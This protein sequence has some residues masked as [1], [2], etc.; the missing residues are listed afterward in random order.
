[1]LLRLMEAMKNLRITLFGL[2]LLLSALA[3]GP[4][5]VLFAT[6][7]VTA[8]VAPPP[9]PLPSATHA[10]L[11]TLIPSQTPIPRTPLPTP[12]GGYPW[13]PLDL[14]IFPGPL[15]YEGDVLTIEVAVAELDAL[16]EDA[17]PILYVD[18]REIQASAQ[19]VYHPLLND[20]F[21][22]SAAWDSTG[23]VGLHEITV[24]VPA[25]EP[26]RLTTV[27]R[28]IE[29]LPASERPLQERGAQWE[30]LTTSCCRFYYLSGTAAARDIHQIAAQA[31][32]SIAGVEAA[33]PGSD[34]R[35]F[36]IV[37]IDNMWGNGAYATSSEI[38][39]SYVDRA[40]NGL[41]M[42]TLIAH[43]AT[44]YA[45]FPLAHQTPSILV[46]GVAV[47]VAGGHYGIDPIHE[48]AAALRV[49]DLYIPL[50][51]LTDHFRDSQ[52]EIAYLE[53]A[54]LVTY[55]TRT[56][57]WDAFLEVYGQDI[58][59]VY[60]SE[61]L[62]QAFRRV[63]GIGLQE[64]ERGFSAWLD[65]IDP[66]GQVDDLRLTIELFD[67][68]REYQ[69]RYAIYQQFPPIEDAVRFDRTY[70]FIREPTAPENLALE[71]LLFSA[72]TALE[73]GRYADAAMLIEA[74]AATLADGDFSRQPVRDYLVIARAMSALGF[75]V[76]SIELVGDEAL[77]T[78][79]HTWPQLET[80]TLVRSGD[81]WT[82]L[83]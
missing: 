65:G 59:N 15:H 43:E 68:M 71:T 17:Q 35:P 74:V 50:A 36:P 30:Q 63:Y 57:G 83:E 80:V 16:P 29:I 42:Q 66:G 45:A 60:D 32:E 82:L 77:V 9:S 2:A 38:V 48:R 41:D 55:L 1:M 53:G 51:D 46:E 21:Q 24:E 61:W 28:V 79:I 27:S 54:G 47:Y 69:F 81:T 10:P 5:I 4:N 37:L 18:G 11:P 34:V 58:P 23:Q 44:H 22:F 31:E 7:P 39:I 76:Q 8:A 20:F 12:T 33:F 40:Y 49:L 26:G 75:E 70:E 56:Y 73:E 72:Q 3:C 6:P 14:R 64:V 25:D 19:R 62:D 78:V 52:H 13:Q 67:I